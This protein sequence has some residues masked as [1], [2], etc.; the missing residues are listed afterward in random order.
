MDKNGPEKF[1]LTDKKYLNK[2]IGIENTHI[3]EKRFKVSHTF[4]IGR[5]I[6]ILNIDT[7]D[8][9]M[10]TNAKSP[11]VRNPLLHK[12]LSGKTCKDVRKYQM[13]VGMLNYLQG[14]S[15]P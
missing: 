1:I 2:F 14:N 3:D 11:P 12:H 8:Y 9:G 6:S 10:D 15:C 13:E 5:I 7:N 4:L